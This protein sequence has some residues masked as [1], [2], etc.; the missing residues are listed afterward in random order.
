MRLIALSAGHTI[1]LDA[2]TGRVHSVFRHACN[3]HLL[4]ETL[5]TL[6]TQE[7]SDIPQG[8][9]L[10]TPKGFTFPDADLQAGQVVV[11]NA[12]NIR[13]TG[14]PLLVDLHQVQ[15]WNSDM[16]ALQ[17][18]FT[19]AKTHLGWECAWDALLTF[20]VQDGLGMLAGASR[21]AV[22]DLIVKR[23]TL[24]AHRAYATI[25]SLVQ[26]TQRFELEAASRAMESLVGLGPGLTPS[27]DDFLVGFIAGLWSASGQD[28]QRHAYISSFGK[29]MSSFTPRTTDVSRSYLLHAAEGRVSAYLISV[30]QALACGDEAAQ[31][32]RVTRN[33]LDVGNSSG[34]DGVL[35]LL[36]GLKTWQ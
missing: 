10:R 28:R 9:R 27:G 5:V 17:I 19:D 33:A 7:L 18:D 4:D 6:I 21:P 23:E 8:I 22:M 24:L 14:S 34:A 26:N 2:F 31:V 30:V 20:Q 32:R 13:F 25:R 3:L 15:V 16:K 12:G 35:G 29:R 1:P 36:L 11:C